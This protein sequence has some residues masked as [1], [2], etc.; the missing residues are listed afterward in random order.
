MI[1]KCYTATM[2]LFFNL[3]ISKTHQGQDTNVQ[4]S[5]VIISK[6]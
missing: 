2:S 5:Q 6:N 3:L 4:K 1:D